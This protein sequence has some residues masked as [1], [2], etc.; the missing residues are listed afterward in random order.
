MHE[1]FS[2]CVP[3]TIVYCSCVFT[4]TDPLRLTHL[5]TRPT[6]RGQVLCCWLLRMREQPC[7]FGPQVQN[8]IAPSAFRSILAPS[9]PDPFTESTARFN[10]APIFDGLSVN[11][12]PTIASSTRSTR[13]SKPCSSLTCCLIVFH[14]LQ[15]ADHS[16][17]EKR[18]R[19][20]TRP[21]VHTPRSRTPVLGK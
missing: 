18:S 15:P 3:N 10:P 9:I 20:R 19:W 12:A 21:V 4:F 6:G 8:F 17:K 11:P 14:A 1:T 13:T 7:Q 5:I 16:R 2:G